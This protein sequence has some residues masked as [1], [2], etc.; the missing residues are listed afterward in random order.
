MNEDTYNK[1]SWHAK[2][3]GEN[4]INKEYSIEQKTKFFD[5]AYAHNDLSVIQEVTEIHCT[6][7]RRQHCLSDY[8]K[9]F[10]AIC[11]QLERTIL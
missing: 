10:R 7:Q 6:K 11:R 8:A 5:Y 2:I 4:I 1:D 9:E 3:R